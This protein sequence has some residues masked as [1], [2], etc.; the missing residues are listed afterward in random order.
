MENKRIEGPLMSLPIFE[1]ASTK[2]IEATTPSP[3]SPMQSNILPTID[4][5]FCSGG[6]A[7]SGQFHESLKHNSG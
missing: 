6:L 5:V 7:L 4:E 1:N 3:L 2:S